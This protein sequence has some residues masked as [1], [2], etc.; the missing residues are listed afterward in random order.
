MFV[1]RRTG[2]KGAAR[3]SLV[4]LSSIIITVHVGTSFTWG[5]V[6]LIYFMEGKWVEEVKGAGD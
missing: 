6:P 3:S 5:K 4:P 2:G 1:D